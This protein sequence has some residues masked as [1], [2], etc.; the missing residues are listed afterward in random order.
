[1]QNFIQL[2]PY[3]LKHIAYFQN[4][5]TTR[6]FFAIA[7]LLFFD[8]RL[9]ESRVSAL[10]AE[11]ASRTVQR[12]AQHVVAALQAAETTLLLAVSGSP[13]TWV[14]QAHRSTDSSQSADRPRGVKV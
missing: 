4:N 3:K 2:L 5:Q 8:P 14:S 1:M 11:S 10:A 13:T 6:Y 12:R 9:T 7:Y